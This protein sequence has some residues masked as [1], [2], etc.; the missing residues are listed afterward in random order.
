MS[1]KHQHSPQHKAVLKKQAL[2]QHEV[3]EVL[4]VIKKYAVPTTVVVLVVCGIFLFDRYLKASKASKE[5]EAST[6]LMTAMG[7]ADYEDILDEYGS[8]SSAPLA[9]MQLAMARFSEGNYDAAQELYSRFLK[10]YEKNDMALEAELNVITCREAKGE[11]SEAHLL[12]GDFKDRHADS[13]LAPFAMI[14][15]AR[16]LEAMEN[17]AEA[18]RTYEDLIV[19]YPGSSWAD[20]AETRMSV[21]ESKIK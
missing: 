17:P 10:K 4:D 6:A 7:A 14:G 2:E 11:F 8:T 3:K 5:A 19:A 18:K 15:Q 20:L 21:I 1:D 9:M 13:Y 16:C 12:Y